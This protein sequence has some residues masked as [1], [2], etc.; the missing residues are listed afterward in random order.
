MTTKRPTRTIPLWKVV[1]LSIA[2]AVVIL[3]FRLLSFTLIA[4]F[5]LLVA[6]CA[7]CRH[8]GFI[9]P[10][11]MVLAV[12]LFL[13]FDIAL[14]GYHFGSRRGTSSGGPHLVEFVVG[15]PMHTL[16]IEECGEYIAGGCAW[17]AV[18]PPRWI[19]V[20]N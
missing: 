5:G 11:S 4:I 6:C 3:Q 18:F 9:I 20:W 7:P 13:P 2:I 19:L 14:G 1:S 15:L 10:A 17:P 12:S 16:L 8:K